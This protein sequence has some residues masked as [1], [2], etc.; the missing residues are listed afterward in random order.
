MAFF[1]LSFDQLD[2]P[3]A[4]AAEFDFPVGVA[5]D[6]FESSDVAFEGWGVHETAELIEDLGDSVVWFCQFRHE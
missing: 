3:D 4:D 2:A 5:G 1:D 6:G